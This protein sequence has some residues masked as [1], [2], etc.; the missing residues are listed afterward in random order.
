MT[1]IKICGLQTIN[2]ARVAALGGADFLGFVFAP[3]RRRVQ[4][5]MVRDI[6]QEVRGESS[7]RMVGV[8]VD[9]EPAEMNRIAGV[10]GLDY[11]QLSGDEDDA[12]IEALDLPAID[13]V[14]VDRSGIS[15]ALLEKIHASRAH[16]VMLDTAGT[17]ARGGTGETFDWSGTDNIQRPFLL[18]GGLRAEN[19]R[20][21]LVEAAPWGVDVSSGV[22]TDG[23]KDSARIEHFIRAVRQASQSNISRVW[24][25]GI[26]PGT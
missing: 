1:A 25:V 26:C 9:A 24:E 4:P 10:C 23:R 8:F 17:N 20:R 2:A 19:V 15:T 22:E 21:A 5:E 12:V 14:H 13:V 11:V 6:I 7:P 18:A 16:L 3:S